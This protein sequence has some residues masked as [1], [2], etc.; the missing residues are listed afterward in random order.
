[1]QQQSNIKIAYN[2]DRNFFFWLN[3]EVLLVDSFNVNRITDIVDGSVF[4]T[5]SSTPLESDDF[6]I[7]IIGFGETH[8]EKYTN[9]TITLSED[10]NLVITLQSVPNRDDENTSVY[11]LDFF[12]RND[13]EINKTLYVSSITITDKD[14][15]L[16]TVNAL[17]QNYSFL[18]S[19][20]LK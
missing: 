8:T 11:K 6:S 10:G 19:C 3:D 2:S 15:A 12:I 9:N 17:K 16:D 13:V 5:K 7:K 18:L 1:M 4:I 20:K 14:F